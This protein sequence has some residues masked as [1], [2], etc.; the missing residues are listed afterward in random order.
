[1]IRSRQE[2]QREGDTAIV[3]AN[4]EPQRRVLEHRENEIDSIREEFCSDEEWNRTVEIPQCGSQSRIELCQLDVVECTMGVP[5]SPASI[6]A[7]SRTLWRRLA[8][9][10]YIFDADRFDSDL[11]RTNQARARRSPS[12]TPRRFPLRFHAATR[13]IAMAA[14]IRRADRPG[15]APPA[16]IR[17]SGP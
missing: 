13:A 6:R 17:N 15:K 8:V 12:A 1:M 11:D 2:I 3:T 5:E 10:D 14:E 4:T 7:N 16:S 9:I